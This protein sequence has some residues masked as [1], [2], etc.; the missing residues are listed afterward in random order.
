MLAVIQREV[1]KTLL[2]GEKKCY[3]LIHK[4]KKLMSEKISYTQK[5]CSTNLCYK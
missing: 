5:I 2:G 4:E 1:N 3:F